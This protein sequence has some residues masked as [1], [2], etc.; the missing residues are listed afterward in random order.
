MN[1]CSRGKNELR[2]GEIEKEKA[3]GTPTATIFISIRSLFPSLC[4]LNDFSISPECRSGSFILSVLC[5][6]VGWATIM[7]GLPRAHTK[8]N[9]L[10]PFRSRC[11]SLLCHQ[12]FGHGSQF[13]LVTQLDPSSISFLISP[14]YTSHHLLLVS[15]ILPST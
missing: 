6:K 11:R 7:Q 2:K 1:E 5:I 15:F 8:F 4:A 9:N 10:P 13:S 12:F 3:R 14:R